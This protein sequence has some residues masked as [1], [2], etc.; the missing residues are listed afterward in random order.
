MDIRRTAA[1]PAP[2]PFAA[3]PDLNDHRAIETSGVL[4]MEGGG[5]PGTAAPLTAR[6]A[7]GSSRIVG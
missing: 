6:S 3:T 5:E 2:S 1:A 7:A 4:F